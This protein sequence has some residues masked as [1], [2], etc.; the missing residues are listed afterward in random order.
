[1]LVKLPS[2]IHSRIKVDLSQ[3]VASAAPRTIRRTD[4]Q[5]GV[6]S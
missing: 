6:L 3:P 2:L 1:M 5:A 4:S